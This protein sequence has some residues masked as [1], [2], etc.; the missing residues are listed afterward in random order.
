MAGTFEGALT[1]NVTGNVTGTVSSIANH[2]TDSLSEGSSNLYHTAAR[3][4]VALSGSTGITYDNSTGAISIDGTVATLTGSQTL[5]NK[6][7]NL[8]DSNDVISVIMVTVSNASGSNKYLLDGET[9]GNIQ[10]TPGVTY[11]FDMSD[12]SN[13]GHPFKFSTTLDGTHNSGS[14]YT[15]GVTTNGTAGSSG[16]YVD[17]KADASTPDRLFYYC[18]NHSGMGG[19]LLE[20]AGNSMVTFAVTVANVSGNKYHLDGETAAS[21]QLVPGTVYRFDQGDSSNSGHPF[22]LSTTKDGTHNSGSQYTTQVS[23]SGTPGTAGAY[24]QIIVDAA[25]ADTLYYYCTAHSGMGGNGVVSVQGLS[26]S[27][28]DTD[29]LSE[30]S[31]NLY[32]T[33]A[34]AR[35]AIS[36]TDSGGDGSLAYNSST[37]VIT[38][39]GPSAS[40]VR[41]HFTGGTG[42]DITSG[43]VA[44]DNTVLTSSNTTDDVTEGSSNLYHTTARARGAISVTDA[45][46]DGSLA[47]NSSTGVITYTGPSA[48]EVRAHISAGTGVSISSGQIA[49]G[50]SVGTSDNVTFNNMT[51]SGNLTVSGTTTTINTETLT[52]DDNII[53]LN[54]NATGTPSENAGIEIERGS[55]TNVTFLYDESADKWTV[56]SET[57]VAGTF[58]GNLTGNVTGNVT[59]NADTATALATARTIGGV[60][61]DGTANI[62]LP[63][64]NTT[65]NQ[66]TSGSAATLTTARNFS[67]T[68][69]VTASAVSFDGSGATVKLLLQQ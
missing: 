10:L 4:R 49:I 20:V 58:E 19:G 15:T 37:G 21:I 16:A 41:A 9:V 66:N 31:S 52:V 48:S 29:A 8:E 44:I 27:D 5:T 1:G 14:E 60:S 65:G 45:G 50:Q 63:G 36:V 55:S 38:Y 62:D 32:F 13:S 12:N 18:G 40:E 33:N 53:V 23:T 28:S 2:D 54:N 42:I 47:Y 69:D 67:L 39:T 26:L 30:G 59:G 61:F 17:I 57:F 6:T 7:I 68:G 25:T 64:V 34:R 22:R 24:T 35:S 11:R 3:A 43:S 51:V 56:G 46:G